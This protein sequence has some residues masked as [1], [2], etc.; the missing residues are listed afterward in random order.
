MNGPSATSRM[1]STFG[2]EIGVEFRAE[3]GSDPVNPA[4]RFL[5]FQKTRI[6]ASAIAVLTLACLLMLVAA[7]AQFGAV[8]VRADDWFAPWSAL[9]HWVAPDDV[10]QPARWSGSAHVLWQIRLPRVMFALGIGAALGLTGA[11]TQGL[12]RNPLADPG[13]LGVTSGAACAAALTIVALAAVQLPLPMAWRPYLLPVSAFVGALAVCFVLDRVSRWLVPGSIAGLLL[14]G[15]A[16]NA[17]AAAVIGLCTYLATDE[18]LRSLSFWTLGSL[19]G[20]N[21][22]LVAMLFGLTALAGWRAAR[23]ARQLNALALG[24]AAA[25]HVGI[26]VNS[27]RTRAT[28][29]VALVCGFAV[30]WCG[31]IGFIGLIAPHVARTWVGPDQRRLLPW[32]A[33]VG[34]V[35]LLLADTLARSVVVPAEVPVGIF[36]ALL[37]GPFFLV[38]L[39]AVVRQRGGQA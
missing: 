31:M 27:L 8:S 5:S 9:T 6:T 3:M 33:V 12:F 20:A 23:L 2:A 11:L 24:E 39:R 17:V 35:L 1:G 30:A 37:G 26:D 38:M 7:A 21:W 28:V 10:T 13:L 22:T 16:L 15:V 4:T 14:S 29:W 32:A 36:S 25:A 19:A 18:Q 34:A